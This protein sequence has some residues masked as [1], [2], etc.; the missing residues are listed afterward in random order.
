ME[1][2][3]AQYGVTIAALA[4][5]LA[6]MLALIG[7]YLLTAARSRQVQRRLMQL[8]DTQAL[9]STAN[10]PEGE[11]GFMVRW[12]EPVGNMIMP[13]QNWQQSNLQK[14]LVIAGFRRPSA[15]YMLLAGKLILALALPL[16]L[17]LV[18][19]AV[20]YGAFLTQALGLL[21][22][23]LV[24][25]IGFLL[26][27]Y[28]LAIRS[29]KRRN[30]F[31]EAFPD[32]L[33]ML[34]ICVEAGLGLDAAINRVARELKLS[35]PLLATELELTSVETRAGKSRVE[36]LK[37]MAMRMD[38]PQASS[39]ANLIIQA[40]RYGTSIGTALRVYAEEMRVER[41]QR[42]K[43]K[44]AKLPTQ[45]LIPVVFCIFPALFLIILGPAVISIFDTLSGGL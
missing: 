45:L 13:D 35:Y 15:V 4:T 17:A 16:L 31:T 18:L 36:A 39:L 33:D 9:S 21:L 1:A 25:F 2:F 22:V 30:Q 24:S 14:Q 10:T 7:V 27:D 38:I 11:D 19:A 26:P 23:V 8:R 32:A 6:V 20:G 40:E 37:S 43:T 3:I 12:L 5:F 42:A 28:Y 34:V 29:Q 41:I 44:A